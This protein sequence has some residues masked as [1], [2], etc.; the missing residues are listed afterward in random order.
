MAWINALFRFDHEEAA[1]GVSAWAAALGQEVLKE[2]RYLG[3]KVDLGQMCFANTSGEDDGL[4]PPRLLVVE[5]ADGV[6]LKVL[7]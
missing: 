2:M 4:P 1:T 3:A 7:A 5:A 6:V